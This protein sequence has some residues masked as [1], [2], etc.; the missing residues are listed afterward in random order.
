MPK[1]AVKNGKW[2][3]WSPTVNITLKEKRNPIPM[4]EKNGEPILPKTN[5]T[6]DFD[7]QV[8]DLIAPY[9]KGKTA[10][11]MLTYTFSVPSPDDEKQE[12]IAHFSLEGINEHE[13]VMVMK[14]DT[15]SQF[16]SVYE[17]PIEGYGRRF[18]TLSRVTPKARLVFCK[19]Q[20]LT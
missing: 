7:F 17:S 12:Y 19:I 8:G 16:I 20:T 5:Q 6:F 9:G 10:D 2:Q 13:G 1:S 18:E 3:P 11:V 4:H 15:W 14:S